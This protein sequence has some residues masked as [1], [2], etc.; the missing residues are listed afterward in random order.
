MTLTG[1]SGNLTYNMVQ[2]QLFLA[3]FLKMFVQC[4]ALYSLPRRSRV[5]THTE[6]GT[7]S[8]Y[9]LGNQRPEWRNKYYRHKGDREDEYIQHLVDTWG[10]IRSCHNS[11]GKGPSEGNASIGC[12]ILYSIL[13]I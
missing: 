3:K 8:S 5:R 11:F 9:C 12:Q 4:C 10:N 6:P 13:Q 7:N 1:T 2:L